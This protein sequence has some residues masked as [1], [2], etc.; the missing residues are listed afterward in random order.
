MATATAAAAAQH[1]LRTHQFLMLTQW[2]SWEPGSGAG[3]W[4]ASSCQQLFKIHP[5]ESLS[6]RCCCCC[7][8]RVWAW[9]L[10]IGACKWGLQVMFSQDI[11]VSHYELQLQLLLLL[12]LLLQ[13]LLL[14]L[15]LLLQLLLYV[16]MFDVGDLSPLRA[17][18]P[19]IKLQKFNSKLLII[20]C[21]NQ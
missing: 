14:L 6:P 11:K 18:Q 7:C 13:L 12:L 20:F 3:Y 5:R 9:T 8:C 4:S 10:G 19:L 17:Q 2:R 21:L 16:V 15:L 1:K